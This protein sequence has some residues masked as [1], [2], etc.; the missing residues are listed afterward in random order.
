MILLK[1]DPGN[2]PPSCGGW[3]LLGHL[4]LVPVELLLLLRALS[5]LRDDAGHGEGDDG[6]YDDG[7]DDDGEGDDHADDTDQVEV[8]VTFFVENWTPPQVRL[9][10]FSLSVYQ[11]SAIKV[12]VFRSY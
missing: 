9:P 10:L 8:S 3:R 7:D 5:H 12:E 11:V 6:E 1:P 4:L 2:R